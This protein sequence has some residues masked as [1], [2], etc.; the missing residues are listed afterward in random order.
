M[1]GFRLSKRPTIGSNLILKLHPTYHKHD[2]VE[3]S[4]ESARNIEIIAKRLQEYNGSMLAID[5]GHDGECKDTFRVNDF[6]I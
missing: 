3:L 4:V 5:Y 1:L 6:N 2:H